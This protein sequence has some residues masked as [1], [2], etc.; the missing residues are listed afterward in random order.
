MYEYKKNT[1]ELE[2]WNLLYKTKGGLSGGTLRQKLKKLYE[3]SDEGYRAALK[4]LQKEHVIRYHM[5]KWT[6]FE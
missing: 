3:Y 5:Q 2:I 6:L 4:S 1:L